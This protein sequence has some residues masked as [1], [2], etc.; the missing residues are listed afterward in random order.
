MSSAKAALESDT[1]T[2]AFEAGRRWGV[3]VN[4]ISAGPLASR[5]ASAIGFIERMIEYC[6]GQLRRSPARSR[7]ADVGPPPRS[8]PARWPRAI[9]G[10]MVYVD[11]GYHAWAWRIEQPV[12]GG[13]D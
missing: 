2:L 10:T 4:T 6:R 13:T 11:N 1:R 12:L 3:R 7:P 9:T 8:W 5:A